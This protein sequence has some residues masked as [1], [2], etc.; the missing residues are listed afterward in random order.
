MTDEAE[1]MQILEMIE[2]GKISAE[3]GLT[4]L[5]AL[6]SNQ[7]ETDDFENDTVDIVE[8]SSANENL[9]SLAHPQAGYQHETRTNP[10][11]A[12]FMTASTIPPTEMSG[13]APEETKTQPARSIPEETQKW[14]QFWTIPFWIGVVILII[15]GGLMYWA[16]DARGAGVA[17]ILASLPFI[18]GLGIMI[19]SWQSRTAPWL[20]IR[21]T[22]PAGEK[23][24]RIAL[25]FPLPIRP[26]LWFFRTFGGHIPKMQDISLDQILMAVEQSTNADNPIFIQVDEGENG[27]KVEI[28][29]G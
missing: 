8:D 15:G 16:L 7:A 1:R 17:F 28:Y 11:A 13:S 29:I 22:Q 10:T 21:I 19:I 12:D 23:P 2:N 14:R 24:E 6:V 9:L 27:E 20:H 26:A 25:S 3:D 5:R 4:L 18:L